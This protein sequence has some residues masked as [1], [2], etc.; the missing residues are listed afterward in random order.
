MWV[1]SIT[2][3]NPFGTMRHGKSDAEA[4]GK[5]KRLHA[6]I[7]YPKPDGVLSFDRL[8]NVSFSMTNHEESQPAHLTLKDASIPVAVNLP[9]MPAGAALLPGRRL[10]VV[11]EERQGP[12][13]VIN[14]QNCVH[15]KTCDIKDPSPEHPLD[16]AA[17]RRRAELSQ[18]VTSQAR[19]RPK[20]NLKGILAEAIKDECK[21][22]FNGV[23]AVLAARFGNRRAKQMASELTGSTFV[24]A[25]RSAVLEVRKEQKTA[26]RQQARTQAVAAAPQSAGS[27]QTTQQ[28]PQPANAPVRPA[29]AAPAAPQ[30]VGPQLDVAIAKEDMFKCYRG[31]TDTIGAQP[32]R[33]VDEVVDQVLLE[34]SDHTR[35]FFARLFSAYPVSP[36]KQS[37]K[38]RETIAQN[39]RPAI[40]ERVEALRTSNVATGSGG[41]STVV[42]SATSASQ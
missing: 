42:K 14:F 22:S 4:T 27:A 8:T 21:S 37:E 39:Y 32:G 9:N 20:V 3:W 29:A 19:V 18:H 11:E 7:D 15:C 28:Q 6:P 36:A 5:A 23:S 25:L 33:S 16:G 38:M 34:C 17:G 40:A 13:F 2:G 41:A 30:P 12:R 1:G 35:A 24:P 26:Q 31:R 10:R